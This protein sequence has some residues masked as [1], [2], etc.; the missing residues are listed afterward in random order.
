[1]TSKWTDSRRVS[2]APAPRTKF[3][4][5]QTSDSSSAGRERRS[6][7]RAVGGLAVAGLLAGCTD[8][9][10]DGDGGGGGASSV[11]EW[12]SNTDNYDSVRDMTDKD[13]VTV[14][15]GPES[16][17]MAF[18]PPAIRVRP[19][20]TVTWKWVGSGHHNVVAEGGEFDSGSPET[21][22]TF[23]HT[24]ETPETVLYY[25]EPHKSAGMKGA[26]VVEGDGDGENAGNTSNRT[27]SQ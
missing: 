23:E 18:A 21:G 5:G 2:D 25:C 27:E 9:G 24:F 26:I 6:F 20:T 19:G 13:A 15:V 16:N 22:A 1:M 14:E 17:E 12:L 3:D 8:D 4:G 10:N 11:D 7:L